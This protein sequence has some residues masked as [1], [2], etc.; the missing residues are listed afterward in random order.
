MCVMAYEVNQK[1]L[2]NHKYRCSEKEFQGMSKACPYKPFRRGNPCGCPC[3]LKIY[4]TGDDLINLLV[5]HEKI[6][7][8][9]RL[10]A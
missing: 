1:G 5:A 6:I 8:F 10:K 7:Y 3:W 9:K 4:K 2:L